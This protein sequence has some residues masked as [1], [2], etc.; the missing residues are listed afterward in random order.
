M[1]NL[2]NTVRERGQI[3]ISLNCDSMYLKLRQTPLTVLEREP[4]LLVG[5]KKGSNWERMRKTFHKL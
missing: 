4:L 5:R 3:Q 2:I 1:I